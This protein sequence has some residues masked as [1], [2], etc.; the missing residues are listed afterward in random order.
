[1]PIL[2]MTVPPATNQRNEFVRMVNQFD[3]ARGAPWRDAHRPCAALPA[4]LWCLDAQHAQPEQRDMI[5]DNERPAP[6]APGAFAAPKGGVTLRTHQ[7]GDMG[8]IVQAHG[9]LY[10]RE[11]GLG[12][13]FEALVA[14][15]VAA[16]LRTHDPARERCWIAVRDGVRLG[17]VCLVREDD[18]V[19]KLRVL[20]VDPAA[21]D[22]GV[23]R[24]LVRA[25]IRFARAAGYRAVR[26]WTIDILDAARHIYATEGFRLVDS[27]PNTSFG[28]AVMDETWELAL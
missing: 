20:I 25:C 3:P 7:P 19:A 11:Y 21:R 10:A 14:E 15:I 13:S 2:N 6:Q 12:P 17:S 16:F 22:L 18:E 4:A 5:H 26:L 28:I 27:V 24:A 9:E 23:G 1:M 8:W